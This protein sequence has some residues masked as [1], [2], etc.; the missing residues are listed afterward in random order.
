MTS[1]L[2]LLSYIINNVHDLLLQ[3]SEGFGF[4]LS[5]KQLHFIIVGIIGMIIYF[6]VNALFKYLSK[7][8]IS[9]V[10]FIY[11]TTVLVVLVFG[12]EISQKITGRGRMEFNDITAGLWG[13]VE[14]FGIYLF[15]LIVIYIIKKLIGK[16]KN[17]NEYK[18]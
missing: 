15:I 12:I 11:T 2:K 8:S 9:L 14:F 6:I 18:K 3:I 7:Y 10:S 13:F 1:F 5:D 17:K 4:N 16:Y